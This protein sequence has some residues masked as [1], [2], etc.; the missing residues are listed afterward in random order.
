MTYRHYF[1]VIDAYLVTQT[2]EKIKK[3][4]GTFANYNVVLYNV[5]SHSLLE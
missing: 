4:L 2:F 5:T 3:D 1:S